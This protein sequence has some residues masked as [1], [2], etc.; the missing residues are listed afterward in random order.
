MPVR[1]GVCEMATQTEIQFATYHLKC[2]GYEIL[3]TC[4]KCDAGTVDIV[5]KD[6]D[7]FVFV[8]VF[9]EQD[10]KKPCNRKDTEKL[11]ISWY[12][13]HDMPCGPLRFDVVRLAWDDD[14]STTT[15]LLTKNAFGK[16]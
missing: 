13:E 6:D 3:A 8:S 12:M 7:T 16:L 10:N 1:K 15:S 11:A 4:S 2:C 5:A 14:Y 9:G